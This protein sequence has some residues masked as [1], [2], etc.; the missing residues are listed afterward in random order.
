MRRARTKTH[1]G[2]VLKPRM[3]LE[4]GMVP[5]AVVQEGEFASARFTSICDNRC[6]LL[7]VQVGIPCVVF[8]REEE[9]RDSGGAIGMWTNAFRALDALGVGGAIR[10][11]NSLLTK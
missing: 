3:R 4:R 2:C 5:D 8:E 6:S 7:C 1:Q 11:E 10:R 9:L